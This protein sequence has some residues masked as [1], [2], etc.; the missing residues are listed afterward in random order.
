[1]VVLAAVLGGL[2]MKLLDEW[3]T[4]LLKAWSMK[5]AFVLAALGAAQAALPFF[6]ALMS[7]VLAG[8]ITLCVAVA[9]VVLRILDQGLS[10]KA[11]EGG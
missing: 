11:L 6:G 1:M 5:A 9:I 3:K 4:V 2:K 10:V 8:L 7:P